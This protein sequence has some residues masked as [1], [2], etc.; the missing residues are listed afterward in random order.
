MVSGFK[1]RSLNAETLQYAIRWQN[2]LEKHA[3][4]VRITITLETV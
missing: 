3:K 4:Y 2:S 1:Q